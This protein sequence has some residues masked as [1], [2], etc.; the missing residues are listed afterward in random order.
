MRS[1]REPTVRGTLL[2]RHARHIQIRGQGSS[3]IRPRY[4]QRG[5]FA[6]LGHFIERL[7]HGR[8]IAKREGARTNISW[9]PDGQLLEVNGSQITLVQLRFTV[10]SLLDRLSREARELMFH[11]WPDVDLHGMKD[12]LTSYRLG[13][14]FLAEPENNLQMSFKHLHRRA[15]SPREGRLALQGAG[16]KRALAYLQRRDDFTRLLFAGI[17]MTS[18][19]PARGEELRIIRWANT[20][21]VQRNIVVYKGRIMLLFAYNKVS[22][23]A[24][25]SFYIVR[26]PCPTVERALFLYLAYIRPFTDFLLRQL[27]LVDAETKTN[28]H[29]FSLNSHPTGCFSAADCSKSLEQATP[30]CPVRLQLSIYRHV[31]VAISKKHIPTL[32]EPFDPNVP[33]DRDGFLHLLAFQ[34]GHTPS[35]H[36]SAYALERGYP[37]RLQP[38]LIDRYFENSFIWHRFL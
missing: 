4:L 3:E 19:M 15:F 37:A 20:V 12:K 38:E 8:A 10:H 6:P 7:Q 18:G 1:R 21:A 14:S 34:T 16:R 24:N 23:T 26:V 30:D 25:H 35:I 28:L 36:A 31:A 5:T 17:H 33:K 11:W 9:S 32:L 13:Y 2:S 22:T 27:K 29:L